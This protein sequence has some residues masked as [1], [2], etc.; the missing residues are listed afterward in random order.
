MKTWYTKK[1]EELSKGMTQ[2]AQFIATV[3]HKRIC[4]YWTNPSGLDPIS[5]NMIKDEIS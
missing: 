4:S 2:K 3:I 1:I 5:T